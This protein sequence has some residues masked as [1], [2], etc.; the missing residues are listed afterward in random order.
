MN[1]LPA[2]Y[3]SLPDGMKEVIL[4][5]YMED[6]RENDNFSSDLG[7]S[8]AKEKIELSL[9]QL[10][11]RMRDSGRLRVLEDIHARCTILP[12]LWGCIRTITTIWTYPQ[13]LDISQGF[14][15]ACAN[16]DRLKDLMEAS[17]GG[18]VIAARMQNGR[19]STVPPQ[20]PKFCRDDPS[21][22][23]HGPRDCY[24]ELV[25]TGPGLHV[26]ITRKPNRADT[27]HEIHIDKFQQVCVPKANGECQYNY[28]TGNSV[29]HMWDA[30][31][32]W[33]K[34]KA[35]EMFE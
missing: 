10:L 13:G 32:W 34:K 30:G 25:K 5:T 8:T 26:C 20:P 22:T 33:I 19:L 17:T 21:F 6:T 14:N 4:T 28:A 11:D 35:K 7:F 1:D 29:R 2:P 24:R 12:S 3:D 27:Q 23:A 9:E 15:F 16:A 18:S 31:P